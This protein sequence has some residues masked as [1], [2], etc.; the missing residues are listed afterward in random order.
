[1]KGA[2]KSFAPRAGLSYRLSNKTVV[3]AGYGISYIFRRTSQ[4]NFPMTQMEEFT[5]PNSFSAA[6]SLA[7]GFGPPHYVELPA[8]GI[9]RNAPLNQSYGVMPEDPPHA[10]IQSWNLAVQRLLPSQFTLEAAYVGN[11]GVDIPIS[12][13]M[14][15]GEIPGAGAAGQPL[16]RLFGRRASTRT[17]V[18]FHSNYHALQVKLDRKFAGGFMLTTAYSYSK[19][20]DY[21][22]DHDCGLANLILPRTNRARSGYDLTHVFVQSYIYELPFGPKGRWLQSGP[23][24]WVLGDWQL[25]GILTSQT[26]RPLDLTYSSTP[27]NAP[28]NSNR[29]NVSGKPEIYGAVGRGEKWFNVTMFS[30]PPAA[31]FGNTGRNILSGP[32]LVNLDLSLFRR[33]RMTE[34][35]TAELRA[36]SFNFTNTP[37]FD[38]PSGGFGS[39][40][41][42]EVT[43]AANDSRTLQFGLKLIF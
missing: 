37:H 25:N 15:F 9:I 16:N 17:I 38:N 36:E 5:A 10:Y 40:G 18:G 30:A 41:F 11:H 23:G 43:T 8:D 12:Y 19:A 3:R 14:N 34:R 28:F 6:G 42:G 26:G 29:P 2:T 35:F 33:F 32:G 7:S 22:T 1:M 20:I 27:L 21:C 13:E 39:P 24:R 4:S 31:A